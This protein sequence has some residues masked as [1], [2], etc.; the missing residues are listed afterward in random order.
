MLRHRL[1]SGSVLAAA[2]GGVLVTDASFAPFYPLLL[3]CVLFV[4]GF[5]ALELLQLLP[6]ADRPSRG[7]AV[8]GVW[9]TLLAHWG[10]FFA[11]SEDWPTAAVACGL[12]VAFLL[13][14][15]RYDGEARVVRRVAI[16]A[17][18]LVYLGLLPGYL[19][20]LRF[21]PAESGLALAAT[22]FVPKVCD[23][24]AYTTGRLIGR[25]RMTPLVSPK[26]TWEGFAGG[27]LASVGTAVGVHALG[28]SLFRH[29]LP[30]AILF[31]LLV[32][33]AGVLGDLAESLVKRD[34]GAKDAA[35]RVPGFGGVLDVIDSV[36]FAAP[37]AYL[38]LRV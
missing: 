26:K 13:E 8:G 36:L 33:V 19:V 31:G 15:A 14:L 34:A 27:L 10:H 16:V 28:P 7:L 3:G 30:H 17:L 22:I 29:G 18:V 37:V 32:G 2:M 24:G 6:A 11:P 38:V 5:A 12:V 1:I 4:G 9:L 23:I 25:H 21:L 35:A 20:R